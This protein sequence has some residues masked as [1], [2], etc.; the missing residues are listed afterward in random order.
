[1]TEV[2]PVR[3]R[4]VRG[5]VFDLD[6]TLVDGYAGIASAVNAARGAFS[7]PPLTVD[8]VKGRVGLGLLQLM[9]GVLPAG[10]AE[11]GAAIFRETYDRV[12]ESQTFPMPRLTETLTALS[13]RGVR[14]SVAS[15]KPAAYSMRILGRLGVAHFFDA[16]EGPET[17]GALKP[18]PAMILACLRA[19]GV[20]REEALYVGDMTLDAESGRRAGVDVVLVSGGSSLRTELERTGCTVLTSLPE[21]LD[22]LS[23]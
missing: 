20:G 23:P 22:V 21:L 4:R 7:L 12:C 13:A 5:I 2:E 16:V 19:M 1:M 11:A 14:A 8:D 10:A 17:A 15:N 9:E 3:A 18:D 6:G